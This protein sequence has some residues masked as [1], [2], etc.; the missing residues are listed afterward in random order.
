MCQLLLSVF[1][2]SAWTLCLAETFVLVLAGVQFTFFTVACVVLG[3]ELV[4][5][6]ALRDMFWFS[7]AALLQ[8]QGLFWFSHCPSSEEAA[9]AGEAERRHSW[10]SWP[11][12]T[13]GILHYT[14]YCVWQ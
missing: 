1:V 6:A 2:G 7:K 13:K 12:L 9:G 4:M 11:Q 14:G 8:P 3:F 5:K 10:N